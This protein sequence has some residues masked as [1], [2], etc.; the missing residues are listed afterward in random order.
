MNV[1][2]CLKDLLVIGVSCLWMGATTSATCMAG[3]VVAMVGA[4]ASSVSRRGEHIW[5]GSKVCLHNRRACRFSMRNQIYEWMLSALL[6]R[7]FSARR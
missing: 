5:F 7:I 2:G 3:Y 4:L 1:A 6:P